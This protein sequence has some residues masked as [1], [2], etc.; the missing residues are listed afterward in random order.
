MAVDPKRDGHR[1][2]GYIGRLSPNERLTIHFLRYVCGFSS[3]NLYATVYNSG[4]EYSLEMTRPNIPEKVM[5]KQVYHQLSSE[6][7]WKESLK[8]GFQMWVAPFF[9]DIWMVNIKMDPFGSEIEHIGR[10]LSEVLM[11][12]SIHA[13]TGVRDPHNLSYDYVTC[14]VIF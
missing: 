12:A 14:S 3:F 7:V 1:L 4:I 6:W 13:A 8:G 11:R 10:E 2:E 5:L 9:D